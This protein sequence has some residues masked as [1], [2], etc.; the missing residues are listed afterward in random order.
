MLI[1]RNC[2]SVND[3]RYPKVDPARLRC[4][5]CGEARL[6]RIEEQQ[7]TGTAPVAAGLA[8]AVVGG[9]VGGGPGAVLGGLLGLISGSAGPTRDR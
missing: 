5:N 8:G 2:N 9:L 1:C 6:E 3:D 4:G 7:R